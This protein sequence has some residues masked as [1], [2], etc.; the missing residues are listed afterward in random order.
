MYIDRYCVSVL[1]YM[2]AVWESD[3][4]IQIC[5]LFPF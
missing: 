5:G 1:I 2:I 3:G 4:Y